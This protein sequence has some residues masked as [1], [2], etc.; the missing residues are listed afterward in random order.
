[1]RDGLVGIHV[2]LKPRQTSTTTLVISPV[3]LSDLLVQAGVEHAGF[4]AQMRLEHLHPVVLVEFLDRIVRRRIFQIAK[5][6][7]LRR[8]DFDA[9]RL[10][11]ARDAVITQRAL[12]R[13]LR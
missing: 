5:D 13:R 1:M 8:A 7:R 4:R 3:M 11:S 2:T 12:L 10:Q 9:R 6:A